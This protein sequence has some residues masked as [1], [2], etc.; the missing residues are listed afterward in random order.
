MSQIVNKQT[1]KLYAAH[2]P[3]HLHRSK[4]RLSGCCRRNPTPTSSRPEKRLRNYS[5]ER[6]HTLSPAIEAADQ[7]HWE[8]CG[9]LITNMEVQDILRWVRGGPALLKTSIELKGLGM[10]ETR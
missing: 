10:K 1:E 6:H 4:A 5:L 7:D 9:R 3:G 2:H 8:N